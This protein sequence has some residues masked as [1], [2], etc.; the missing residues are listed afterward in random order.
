M[1]LPI[2]LSRCPSHTLRTIHKLCPSMLTTRLFWKSMVISSSSCCIAWGDT[3]KTG[4]GV[5]NFSET[6]GD[7]SSSC[8]VSIVPV[9]ENTRI[10]PV[11]YPAITNI[12]LD[13]LGS[14]RF[15]WIYAVFLRAYFLRMDGTNSGMHRIAV[16]V[17]PSASHPDPCPTA[18]YS[19]SLWISS[20]TRNLDS[21][22][23]TR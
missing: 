14:N 7:G 19:P 6:T 17:S 13:P 5:R 1:F 20:S 18:L 9:S 21:C 12:W 2:P 22:A 11:L 3:L 16:I 15:K 10:Q 8:A 4:G 23:S